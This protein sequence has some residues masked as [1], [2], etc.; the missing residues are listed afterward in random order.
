MLKMNN[1]VGF[2]AGAQ[3]NRTF[4][5]IIEDLSLDT[6]LVL[7]Y[8]AGDINSYDPD[9][10]AQ[11]WLDTTSVQ[12][13]MFLGVDVSADTTDPTFNGV[14]GRLT[15]D[16]YFE[17]DGTDYFNF[18]T[19]P[20]PGFVS[21]FH[22][23]NADFTLA[24][25]ARFEA[26]GA[27]FDDTIFGSCE[28]PD[29]SARGVVWQIDQST[30]FISLIVC[31]L[32]VLSVTTDDAADFGVD[33]FYAVSI[34]EAAG[35]GGGFFYRNGSYDQVS[36][37]DTFDATYTSP[38]IFSATQGYNV[39]SLGNGNRRLAADTRIY[40]FHAWSEALSKANLDD[41][42]NASKTRFGL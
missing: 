12:Q 6:N 2:G 28:E 37:L 40:G 18:D 15:K 8:D 31:P 23:N 7:G 9:S 29:A 13:N 3:S 36:S 34:D 1:L 38:S 17:L 39:G 16:E 41:I 20:G 21:D 26:P 24:I 14:A 32:G 42:Y 5:Q 22:Q 11:R 4:Q 19:T 27:S 10:D 30:G 35:S 25:W 33:G